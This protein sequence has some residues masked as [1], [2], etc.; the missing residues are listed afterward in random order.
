MLYTIYIL[1]V[2]YI[3]AIYCCCVGGVPRVRGARADPDTGL[4][5]RAAPRRR[6]GTQFC[7]SVYLLYWYWYKSTNTDAEGG[8]CSPRSICSRGTRRSPP[9]TSR[10][11]CVCVCVCACVCVCVFQGAYTHICIYMYIYIYVCLYAYVCMYVCMYVCIH[12]YIY[13]NIYAASSRCSVYLAL[14]VQKHKH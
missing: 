5:P 14:L 13:M 1:Y 3:H 11:L 12:T 10:F 7:Y 4:G 9:T 6:A 8:A 2:Y